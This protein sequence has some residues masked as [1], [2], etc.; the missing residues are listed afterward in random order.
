[1]KVKEEP[2]KEELQ[3]GELLLQLTEEEKREAEY[4]KWADDGHFRQWRKLCVFFGIYTS[5]ILMNLFIGSK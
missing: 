1:M 4:L 2:K 5:L 3:K